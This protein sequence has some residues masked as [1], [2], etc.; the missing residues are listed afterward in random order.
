MNETATF[1]ECCSYVAA[2]MQD[3]AHLEVEQPAPAITISRQ[4][5]AR[6]R[7]IGKKL[8]YALRDGSPK[9]PIPWTCFDEDLVEK[10]L[11]DHDLPTS[12]A[13][14]MPDDSV[15]EID[16]M[17]N[18]ILG[19]HPSLWTLFEQTVETMVHLCHMGHCILVG[20]GGNI[21]AE[22]LS[23]VTRVRFV[24]SLPQR[25]NQMVKAHGMSPKEAKHY[26]KHEDHARQRYMKNHFDC[27]VEDPL[28]YDLVINTDHY[29]DEA[30]VQIVL[31][32]VAAK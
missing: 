4:A 28:H 29:S 9:D 27:D 18:E 25:I 17:I 15:S 11:K 31:S 5:G 24:G 23:N 26:I 14:F 19:R 3:K 2:L 22:G 1:D 16:S 13:K 8:Q 21:V 6:G 12:L 10:V 20:R 30:V 32:G 7:T